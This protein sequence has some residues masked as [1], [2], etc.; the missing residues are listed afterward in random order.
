V[1][2]SHMGPVAPLFFA[3]VYVVGF[4]FALY[5]TPFYFAWQDDRL[6]V[7]RAVAAIALCYAVAMPFYL[8]FPVNEVWFVHKADN[9]AVGALPVLGPALYQFSG[10]NNNF[11]SL[12][13][14][15]SASLA[16]VVWDSPNRRYAWF[17]A[18]LAACTAVSTVVL[19]IHWTLDVAAGLLLAAGVAWAV[20]RIVPVRRPDATAPTAVLAEPA[21]PA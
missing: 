19:G 14:A 18:A 8:L 13:T 1:V 2:Q 21:P 17:M 3:V 5:F 12:H 16:A 7:R 20:R 11:P 10:V 4:P 9:L 6:R 15:L